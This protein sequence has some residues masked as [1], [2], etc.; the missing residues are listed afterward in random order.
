MLS[1]KLKLKADKVEPRKAKLEYQIV[2]NY[3]SDSIFHVPEYLKC[4]KVLNLALNPVSYTV[5]KCAMG[6]PPLV[7]LKQPS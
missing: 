1:T 5:K 6:L 2:V 7:K 4:L 3:L